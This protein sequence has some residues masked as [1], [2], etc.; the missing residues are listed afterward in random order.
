LLS[1]MKI[2]FAILGHGPN[3]AHIFVHGCDVPIQLPRR[4]G[5]EG[6]S[7]AGAQPRVPDLLVLLLGLGRCNAKYRR[8][9]SATAH[10]ATPKVANFSS[11]LA[12]TTGSPMPSCSCVWMKLSVHQAGQFRKSS[13]K[14]SQS[15]GFLRTTSNHTRIPRGISTDSCSYI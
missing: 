12:N 3:A 2:A 13:S 5:S 8:L 4:N 7:Q 15:L 9:F 10:S 1:R 11:I 14:A 6:C